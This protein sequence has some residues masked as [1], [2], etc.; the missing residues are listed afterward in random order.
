MLVIIAVLDV[1]VL[2]VLAGVVLV[3]RA[4]GA[5][6]LE[7]ILGELQAANVELDPRNMGTNSVP[8]GENVAV[9]LLGMTNQLE[10][11]RLVTPHPLM[12]QTE[13]GEARSFI[14]SE[15]WSIGGKAGG[16]S[17]LEEGFA[18][19][20]PIFERLMAISKRPR[21]AS[22]LDVSK[23][24]A[25]MEIR[26]LSV[27]TPTLGVLRLVAAYDLHN[28]NDQRAAEAVITLLNIFANKSEDEWYIAEM[29]RWTYARVGMWLTWELIQ[30]AELTDGTWKRLQ[31][32][33]E[34]CEFVEAYGRAARREG[35]GMSDYFVRLKGSADYRRNILGKFE[36]LERDF[37]AS[38]SP[39]VKGVLLTLV[40]LPLWRLMWMDQD[41]AFTMRHFATELQMAEF[42]RTNSWAEVRKEGARRGREDSGFESGGWDGKNLYDR[43]RYLFS[44][45]PQLPYSRVSL[46]RAMQAQT[47]ASSAIAAI[48]L[49][50]YEMEFGKYPERLEELVPRFVVKVPKD[51]MDGGVLKYRKLEEEYLLYSSG[52]DGDDDGGS[53]ERDED[54]ASDGM[55]IL[56]SAEDVIWPRRVD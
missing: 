23:G 22:V 40:H 2:L 15:K 4:R 37:G 19:A 13:P 7:E 43:S 18:D 32:G 38:W 39:P 49:R 54:S 16:W 8:E 52:S 28:R 17:D 41:H 1:L 3:E 25:D 10:R 6:Q 20:E 27:L 33:W 24:T 50:R 26:G 12:H 48:G 34:R 45:S 51:S 11:F 29:V 21:F 14:Q 36:T 56:W 30:N 42:A 53:S 35:A 46:L 31:E 47:E 44:F 9:A 55:N 5:R